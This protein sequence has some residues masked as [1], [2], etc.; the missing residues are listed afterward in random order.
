MAK[1]IG[2]QVYLRAL[3][4]EDIDFLYT[5]ENDAKVWE[6]SDTAVP[7]SKFVLSQYLEN[8][9]RDIYE[10]KQL[11]LSIVST[12]TD[13][14][15]GFVDLYDF[16]PK[17]SRAG[18]GILVYKTS[19]RRKGFGKEAVQLME[20]YCFNSLNLNQLYVNIGVENKISLELF[21]KL[22]Y[23][24]IGTKK[25]W[26]FKNGAYQDEMLLQKIKE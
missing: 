25:Q 26:A 1:L 22:G 4:P 5:V 20:N 11:R 7:Y 14:L 13:E 10:V 19:K 8:A 3:E 16:D 6:V 2:A 17:N 15:V 23:D 9:N 12:Q 24:V 21:T 18:L